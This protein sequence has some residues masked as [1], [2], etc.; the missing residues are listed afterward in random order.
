MMKPYIDMVIDEVVKDDADRYRGMGITK[1]D[2]LD[3]LNEIN[4]LPDD[5]DF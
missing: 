3:R 1:E 4:N 2:V 5:L